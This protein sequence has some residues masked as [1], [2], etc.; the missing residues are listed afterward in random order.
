MQAPDSAPEPNLALGHKIQRTL[1]S[2]MTAPDVYRGLGALSA[3]VDR[4]WQGQQPSQTL[5]DS[6]ITDYRTLPYVFKIQQNARQIDQS[7]WVGISSVSDSDC[8]SEVRASIR[9]T[10]EKVYNH[11]LA[12]S[13]RFDQ[14][15]RVYFPTVLLWLANSEKQSLNK[16]AKRLS[17]TAQTIHNIFEALIS[18]EVLMAI[19]PL[20][21]S[22]GK[23]AKPYKHLFVAPAVRQALSNITISSG[24]WD[25]LRGQLLEDT[26][27]FYLK[28]IIIDQPIAD[29][30]EYDASDRGA[31]FIVMQQRFKERSIPIEVGWRKQTDQQV[32]YSLERTKSR[33]YGLV[34]TNSD[35]KHNQS[36]RTVFA[37]LKMFLSAQPSGWVDP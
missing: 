35:L 5:I 32:Q 13:R 28:Q 7:P 18:S 17:L 24:R 6:Y 23:V 2:S 9:S 11:D 33:R 15:T 8:N 34:V 29:L 21:A 37:P 3:E 1:F 30:V 20:G 36:T 22:L 31:D 19:P 12:F 14:S 16:I 26:V 10:L 27:G 4:Y 25:Q